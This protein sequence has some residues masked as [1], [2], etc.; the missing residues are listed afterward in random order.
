MRF[1]VTNWNRYVGRAAV[2]ASARPPDQ[3]ETG[4]LALIERMIA[5]GLLPVTR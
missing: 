1:D 4:P 5:S 2:S 3:V